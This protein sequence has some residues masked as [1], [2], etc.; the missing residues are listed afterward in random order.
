PTDAA[1]G[2]AS[3][4]TVARAAARGLDAAT[5]LARNDAYNFLAASG[6][7]FRTGPTGTNVADIFLAIVDD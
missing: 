5:A 7:L 3:P 6:D 4:A 2:F 1:G